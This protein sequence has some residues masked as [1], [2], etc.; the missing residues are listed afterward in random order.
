ME[1]C[2]RFCAVHN[3]G[4]RPHFF[5]IVI[6]AYLWTEKVND[7]IASVDDNPVALICAFNTD[8]IK[9]AAFQPF[10]KFFGKR[11]DLCGG[12]AGCDNHVVGYGCLAA[13][14]DG[15]NV[16]R[17]ISVKRCFDKSFQLFRSADPVLV[18]FQNGFFLLFS[19]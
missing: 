9:A 15:F 14:V 6:V 3:M 10:L 1:S 18:C 19:Y 5:D 12:A 17:F 8:M 13:Q 16:F 2:G 4:L 11:C 7:N